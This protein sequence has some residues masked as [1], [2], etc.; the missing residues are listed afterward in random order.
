MGTDVLLAV[1]DE[2]HAET[3]REA[4]HAHHVLDHLVRGVEL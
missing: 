1:D 4:H 2:I 3:E